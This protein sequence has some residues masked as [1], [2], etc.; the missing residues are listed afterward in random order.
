MVKLLAGNT[1]MLRRQVAG[2][3]MYRQAS[4][5]NVVLDRVFDGRIL[6]T[7]G[8]QGRELLKNGHVGVRR[9]WVWHA[10]TGGGLQ[11]EDTVNS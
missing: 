5:G 9:G 4:G 8:G 11:S 2:M 10:W 1:Q 7:W 3:G 6:G